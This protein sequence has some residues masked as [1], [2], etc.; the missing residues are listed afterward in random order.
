MTPKQVRQ[1][2]RTMK[3]ETISETKLQLYQ[4]ASIIEII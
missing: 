1:V 2:H 4:P 3:A